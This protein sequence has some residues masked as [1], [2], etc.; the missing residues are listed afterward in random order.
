MLQSQGKYVSDCKGFNKRC[1]SVSTSPA[2]QSASRNKQGIRNSASMRLQMRIRVSKYRARASQTA[3]ANRVK[4][5][6]SRAAQQAL[7][8]AYVRARAKINAQRIRCKRR[9]LNESFNQRRN[10]RAATASAC[11]RGKSCARIAALSTQRSEP[12]VT[13]ALRRVL[14]M[15]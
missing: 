13:C 14:Q 8:N 10:L 2:S 4:V 7:A 5:S 11:R 12:R 3:R 15:R 1:G 6:V 9:A